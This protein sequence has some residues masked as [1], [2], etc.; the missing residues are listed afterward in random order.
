MFKKTTV[1]PV[2]SKKRQEEETTPSDAVEKEESSKPGKRLKRG[3][4]LE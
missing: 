2:N 3:T 1:D 4:D